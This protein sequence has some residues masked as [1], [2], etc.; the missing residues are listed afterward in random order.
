MGFAGSVSAVNT[1]GA[2]QRSWSFNASG[3]ILPIAEP[4]L[5]GA[6]SFRCSDA[7][8]YRLR[9]GISSSMGRKPSGPLQVLCMLNHLHE[10]S[11]NGEAHCSIIGSCRSSAWTIRGQNWRTQSISWKLLLYLRPFA[12]LRVLLDH[13]KLSSPE[14]VT[15]EPVICAQLSI[16]T[17]NYFSSDNRNPMSPHR[18]GR[19]KFPDKFDSHVSL[20]IV[21]CMFWQV[22]L[23]SPPQNI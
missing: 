13:W 14:Q 11:V 9:L 15:R 7:L 2:I 20:N 23:V 8:G 17:P 19:R 10:L 5:T 22:W 21:M 16:S 12:A 4:G 6:L 1:G 18:I 3:R